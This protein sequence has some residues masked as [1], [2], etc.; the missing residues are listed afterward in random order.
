MP[1][2]TPTAMSS[3]SWPSLQ[4]FHT[5]GLPVRA[6][7]ISQVTQLSELLALSGA[8]LQANEPLLILGGGSN[9]LF[10]EDFAGHV[11]VNRLRG[12]RCSESEQA[13]HL[14]VAAGENWHQLVEYTLAHDLPGMENLA[15]IP[16]C[17]GSAPIQNI[18]AYG[19]EFEKVCE[20]VDVLALTSG[21][22][23]RL[24]R[25]E[26]QF[27][28]R[29]SI[30]KHRYQR[31]YVITA[32]GLRLPKAWL[33]VLSYGDLAK[34]DPSS[35]T[36]QQIFTTVCQMRQ[37]KLPDPAQQG[38][39]GSFFKNPLVSGET[40]A[41][42]RQTYPS[43]PCYPQPDG[44]YKLAAGW[45]I[46]QCGLKGH[47]IG[48]AAVHDKQALVLVNQ[49]NATARDVVQL[50]HTVRQQVLARFAVALEPEVRFMGADGEINAV[51]AIA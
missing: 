23:V 27:G 25:E 2:S 21:E 11:I 8:S 28:Y 10:T 36:A 26:C 33:P 16:G 43:I 9:M 17:C 34:L 42:L 18:G 44:Q 40:L 3:A 5:F 30:F 19:V 29:D 31:G 24:S 38:N 51:Q 45:L 7:K 39:A 32:V 37:S 14:H 1:T 20:Y 15:L 35:V 4:P 12:I 46:D 13:W 48:G 50:A 22:T 47:R 41:D 49:G 6:R